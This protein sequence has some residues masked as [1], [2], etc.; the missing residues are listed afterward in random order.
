MKSSSAFYLLF[1]M[2]F[3]V[4]NL[5][6]QPSNDNC[7]NA[8]RIT[9]PNNY[10]SDVA[11]FTN[12]GATTSSYGAAS[13]FTGAN[14]RD[15]WFSFTAVGSDVTITIRGSKVQGGTLARPEVALYTNGC[16]GVVNELRCET[17]NENEGIVELYRGGLTVGASYLIRVQGRS[18]GTGTFQLCMNNY[19]PPLDPGSDCATASILCDK[20]AFV[21]QKVTGAGSNNDE[22]DDTCLDRDK[23]GSDTGPSESS[24]TWFVWTAATAGTLTFNINPLNKGDDI[25]FALFELPNGVSNCSGKRLLRCVATACLGTS[26]STGLNLTS[27]QT[28]EDINCDAGEDGFVRFIDMEEGKSYGLIIN[29]FTSTN[30]GFELEFGGTGEFQGPKADFTISEPDLTVCV[31]QEVSFRDTSSFALGTIQKWEWKFGVGAS[32]PSANTRGA[33]TL[34]YNTPGL[35]SIVLTVT[36][37]KGCLTTIV[38][39]IRVECCPDHFSAASGTA[40]NLTC[41]GSDNGSIDLNIATNYP[42]YSYLWSDSTKVEDLI[43]LKPGSYSVTVTDQATCDTSFSFTI[44]GPPPVNFDTLITKP[45]CGGGRDGSITLNV[46][47]GTPPYQ[48]NWQNAGFQASNT[49]ANIP[50][51]D[52]TVVVRDSNNCDTTLVIPL[53]ELELQL[54]PAVQAVTPPLCNG[55]SDGSIRVEVTNGSGPFQYNFNDGRGF[56]NANSLSGLRAGMYRVDVQDANLCVGTFDFNM[57]DHPPLQI[58]FDSTNASCNGVADGSARAIAT[59]GVGKYTFVWSN[60]ETKDSIF[61]LTDGSYTVTVRDSNQCTITATVVITEPAPVLVRLVE[62]IDVICNGDSTGV[63]TVSGSGGTQPYEFS[64][65]NNIFQSSATFVDV[66]AG[67]YTI[68]IED[69]EGCGSTTTAV[70]NQSPPLVVDAGADTIIDLGTS[71]DL[72]AIANSATVTWEWNPKEKLSCTDCP[73]PIA[74]PFTT[75]TYVVTVRNNQDCDAADSIKITVNKIRPIFIPNAFSPNNDGTNDRF[76]IFGGPAAEIMTS[77]RVFDRWGNLL[78]EGLNLPLG[79]ENVG[80]D[81]MFRGK[82]LGVGVYTY[83]SEIKFIDGE[84]ILYEGDITIVK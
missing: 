23:N 18:A 66:P 11:Q 2:S 74:S 80:W 49:L 34:S 78:F 52:Y 21:I 37:D 7:D 41:P 46:T 81:G 8:I 40:R 50:R 67:N 79:Q 36:S 48:F 17:D 3:G 84:V 71:I 22:A 30:N 59:G 12:V 45:T 77:L 58:T 4:Y 43:N 57:E 15:V 32:I 72:Q 28:S 27:T 20:S 5:Y 31:G 69:A 63:I 62:A 26:G 56:Q 65:G 68:T 55:G 54:N 64:L 25:D 6:A 60:G 29:N 13:C 51:G 38:K 33:H 47:G 61:N 44:T 24:S 75:T 9:N 82:Q 39:T 10:C 14:G 19:Y 76:T 70:I 83:M 35:K 16:G 53:R 73:N 1:L 42:P